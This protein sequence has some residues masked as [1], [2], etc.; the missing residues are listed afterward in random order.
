[1]YGNLMR[2]HIVQIDFWINEEPSRAEGNLT[3]IVHR[4]SWVREP[5]GEFS[6]F[7]AFEN[8]YNQK[9]PA[10]SAF[11][12]VSLLST[13]RPKMVLYLNGSR[14]DWVEIEKVMFDWAQAGQCARSGGLPI[15][16]KV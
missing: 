6:L 3:I 15:T 10:T 8:Q 1:M 16:N 14:S 2:V 12:F 4:C 7:S 9:W 13:K 11:G 5:S